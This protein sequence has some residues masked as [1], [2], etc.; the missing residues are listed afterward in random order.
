VPLAVLFPIRAGFDPI[1]LA[2]MVGVLKI[3]QR[4]IS[5]SRLTNCRLVVAVRND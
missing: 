2:A 1:M 4:A 3:E 5:K